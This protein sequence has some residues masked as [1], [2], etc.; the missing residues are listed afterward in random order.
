MIGLN[1]KVVPPQGDTLAGMYVPGGTNVAVN[2]WALMRHEPTFGTDVDVFR[3]ERFIN[4]TAEERA[5]MQR[6]VDLMFGAGRFMCAGKTVA[7]MELNKIFVEV[8]H[9]TLF[10]NFGRS[11]TDV[12]ISVA[13]RLRLPDYQHPEAMRG[14]SVHPIL[15]EELPSPCYG[16][17]QDYPRPPAQ[18]KKMAK[19][20]CRWI[21]E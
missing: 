1:T 19:Y 4:A 13:P 9:F 3:P 12:T 20:R 16:E 6:T 17:A 10:G 8:C 2:P 18:L 11:D 14:S 7:W 21:S 15:D 5:N